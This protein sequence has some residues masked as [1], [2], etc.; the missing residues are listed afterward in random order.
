MEFSFH[1]VGKAKQKLLRAL[2]E[3]REANFDSKI[4][5]TL[6]AFNCFSLLISAFRERNW[7]R[8]ITSFLLTCRRRRQSRVEAALLLCISRRELSL[9]RGWKKTMR[10]KN[11][12]KVNWFVFAA[13]KSKHNNTLQTPLCRCITEIHCSLLPIVEKLGLFTLCIVGLFSL[14]RVRVEATR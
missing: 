6:C 5:L 8:K 7:I 14:L 1:Y 3:C 11:S 10:V 9:C 13:P 4:P 2:V 12:F